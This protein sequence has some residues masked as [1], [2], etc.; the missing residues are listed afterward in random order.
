VI[1]LLPGLTV[2]DGQTIGQRK[3][4]GEIDHPGTNVLAVVNDQNTAADN[5]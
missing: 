4:F 3:S 1:A 5:L 2:S